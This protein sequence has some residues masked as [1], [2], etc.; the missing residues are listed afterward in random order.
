MQEQQL[1]QQVGKLTDLL[2]KSMEQIA[3][4]QIKGKAREEAR[5]IDVFNAFTQRLKVVLDGAFKALEPPSKEQIQAVIDKAI[6]EA[7]QEGMESTEKA[8]Q[9][10]LDPMAEMTPGPGVNGLPPGVRQGADGGLYMRDFSQ[11]R[12]YRRIS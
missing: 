6:Q 10:S 3:T 1:Q 8:T 5:E 4:L 7:M 11:S 2:T 9:E 12:Q